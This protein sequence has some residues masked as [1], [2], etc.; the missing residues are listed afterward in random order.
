MDRAIFESS[1]GN[2][3]VSPEETKEGTCIV[4]KLLFTTEDQYKTPFYPT[5]YRFLKQNHHT[6]HMLNAKKTQVIFFWSW[7]I[8]SDV[9]HDFQAETYMI[10]KEYLP[11]GFLKSTNS[12]FTSWSIRRKE[13]GFWCLWE[14]QYIISQK[15]LFIFFWDL[16]TFSDIFQAKTYMIINE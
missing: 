2:I 10:I 7:H 5:N 11:T 3:L 4:H 13:T 16:H 8:F 14:F 1:E 9:F 6:R 12:C 15:I